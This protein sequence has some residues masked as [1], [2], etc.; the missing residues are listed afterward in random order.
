[1]GKLD[2]AIMLSAPHFLSNLIMP[3]LIMAGNVFKEKGMVDEAI[4]AF[5]K[6]LSIKPDYAKLLKQ[7]NCIT[8]ARQIR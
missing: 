5:N 6:A 4:K 2:E 1:M 3:K 8:S 7:G